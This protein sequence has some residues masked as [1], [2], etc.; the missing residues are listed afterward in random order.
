MASLKQQA[1]VLRKKHALD[2]ILAFIRT[3][4]ARKARAA[5]LESRLWQNR[6]QPDM[7]KGNG[8]RYAAHGPSRQLTAR[9]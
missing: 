4:E 9:P 7:S 8:A 3:P 5:K 2:S 1:K 6:E